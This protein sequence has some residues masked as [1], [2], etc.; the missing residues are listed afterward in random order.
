M[1]DSRPDTRHDAGQNNSP[2]AP[3]SRQRR[4]SP[5]V[6][7]RTWAREE[8]LLTERG[9]REGYIVFKPSR[10]MTRFFFDHLLPLNSALSRLE[11]NTFNLLGASDAFAHHARAFFQQLADYRV[12]SRRLARQAERLAR[13]RFS[14]AEADGETISEVPTLEADLVALRGSSLEEERARATQEIIRNTE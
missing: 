6:R 8:D 3:E 14:K 9:W 12:T 7:H 1:T 10:W 5:W 4:E 2:S 11:A 13:G